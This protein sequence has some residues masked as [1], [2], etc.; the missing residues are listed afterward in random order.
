[1]PLVLLI[2][3]YIQYYYLFDDH[4]QMMMMIGLDWPLC[5]GFI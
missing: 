5:L 3:D 1:M 2:L 4:G